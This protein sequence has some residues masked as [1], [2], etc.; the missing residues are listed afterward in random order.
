MKT[1]KQLWAIV[2]KAKW[3][4]DHDD[5]RI[6]AEWSKLDEDT[7]KQ[8]EKFINEKAFTLSREYEDAWLGKDGKGGFDVSDDGWMDLTADV[9]G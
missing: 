7:F 3:K 8:L 1:E 2:K 6:K 5:E 4:L 9:V